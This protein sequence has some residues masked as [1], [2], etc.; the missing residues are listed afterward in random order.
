M[1]MLVATAL[2][3]EDSCAQGVGY[4]RRHAG[5][6][7]LFVTSSSTCRDV[8]GQGP[9]P[10][11]SE[12]PSDLRRGD[13]WCRR[14][15]RL[16]Q[17]CTSTPLVRALRLHFGR[18]HNHEL[19]LQRNRFNIHYGR[20][21]RAA[22]QLEFLPGCMLGRKLLRCPSRKA[23]LCLCGLRCFSWVGTWSWRR[24]KRR[25]R[26]RR[27]ARG[28]ACTRTAIRRRIH[29]CDEPQLLLAHGT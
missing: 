3:H 26:R 23:W 8:I 10:G 1:G 17:R 11:V 28:A 6:I 5:A 29:P 25:L 15:I 4:E 22:H 7:R 12:L 14:I 27:T 2:S 13:H 21:C 9:R 19:L 24:R 20:L 16:L 18:R